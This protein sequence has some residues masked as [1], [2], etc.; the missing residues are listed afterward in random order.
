MPISHAASMRAKAS[1]SD[2]P[3]PKNAGA[4]PTP[5]KLPQP[6]PTAET[7]RP[8]RPRFLYST[9]CLPDLPFS[10]ERVYHPRPRQATKEEQLDRSPRPSVVSAFSVPMRPVPGANASFRVPIDRERTGI[11]NLVQR[12]FVYGPG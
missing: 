11:R 5:P 8:V 10:L 12:V 9:E 2:S 6:R 1:S 3:L 4:L 7:F